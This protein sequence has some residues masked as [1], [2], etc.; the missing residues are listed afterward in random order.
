MNDL[1]VL[2]VV[3]SSRFGGG[4][5]I[6]FP[7][8]AHARSEG[9]RVDILVT[10]PVFQQMIRDSG[11]GVGIVD[12]DVIHREIRPLWDVRGLFRL[13]RYLRE[14]PYTVVHTH[15]SKAGL[16]GRVAAKLAGVPVVVH[17]VHGFAFH[18]ASSRA[19]RMFYSAIER[20]AAHF[21]DVLVTVSKF[22]RE[23][24]LS[25]GIGAPEKVVAIP[26]GLP[27]DRIQAT[28]TREEMRRELGIAADETVLFSAG[29]LAPQKGFEY[30]MRSV[31]QLRSALPH[32]FR[33]VIAGEGE[34]GEPLKSLCAQL[35]IEPYVQFLGFR[36]DIGNLL[37]AADIVV[38]PSLWEGLS[39]A[40]LE[41][42]A[43]GK[44]IVTTRIG[45]NFEVVVDGDTALLVD[46]KNVDQLTA[47]IVHCVSDPAMCEAMGRRAAAHFN[48]EYTYDRMLD[49]YMNVYRRALEAKH[50]AEAYAHAH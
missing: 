43:A 25:L 13:A 7:L 28:K 40:L 34:L 24:A 41:A 6:I 30:L 48:A 5:Q 10:D 36:Q 32:P 29:R 33:V 45:S 15:T 31:V 8:A 17:T 39:I 35:G 21:C 50:V 47:A 37:A 38:L 3:G 49:Q 4:A 1:S 2:H 19:A 26:N 12:L 9:W 23:W 22:H 20:A 46:S 18:E 27:P 42:M 11:T 14:H 44:P 16:V